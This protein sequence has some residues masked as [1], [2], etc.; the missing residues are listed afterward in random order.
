MQRFADVLHRI[1]PERSLNIWRG[2]GGV[3][4]Q[5]TARRNCRDGKVTTAAKRVSKGCGCA[6]MPLAHGIVQRQRLLR[7]QDDAGEVVIGKFGTDARQVG[8]NG[9]AMP[10]Q[11]LS[12]PQAGKLQQLRRVESTGCDNDFSVCLCGVFHAPGFV[13]DSGRTLPVKHNARRERVRNN[14][15]VGAI[16]YRREIGCGGG[17]AN[18][19]PHGCLVKPRAFLFCAVEIRV[20]WIAGFHGG[21]DPCLRQRVAVAQIRHAKWPA[22]PVPFVSTTLVIFSLAKVRQYVIKAPARIAQLPPVIEI[23]LLTADINEAVDG[24]RTAQHAPARRDNIA[25]CA[26]RLRFGLVAPVKT[27][28]A[29]KPRVAQRN[30][31]PRMRAVRPGFEQQHFVFTICG[32]AVC[33]NAASAAG[34]T[35]R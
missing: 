23:L 2:S 20:A 16:A 13:L 25:A 24:T 14:L 35:A 30:A 27:P 1:Q 10:T 28:V 33:Q 7:A 6:A 12:R 22:R 18:A 5:K 15:Q 29:E 9:D 11:Q 8:D 26:M 3:R 34:A 4:A 17:T 19:V 21:I 31:Q 32:E